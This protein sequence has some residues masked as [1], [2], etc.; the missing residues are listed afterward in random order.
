MQT[1]D[2][3]TSEWRKT[4]RKERLLIETYIN[5]TSVEWTQDNIA[6]FGG[7]PKRI[8]LWGQSA[9]GAST[10]IY[11]YAWPDDPIVSSLI[12]DSGAAGLLGSGDNQHTNFTFLAGLVGCSGL[13]AQTELSCVRNVSATTLENA[14]SNYS[15]NGTKPAISFTP[16]PDNKTAFSNTT[17]RAVRGLVAKIVS[18]V[19]CLRV[20]S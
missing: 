1:L 4:A 6:A 14:L 12:C 10:S 2:F 19:L 5:W 18:D 8:T 3:L 11:G 17:D 7:D 20:M 16:F 9:G 15:I 13:D